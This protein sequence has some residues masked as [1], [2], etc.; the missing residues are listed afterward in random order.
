MKKQLSIILA[1][2]MVLGS[3]SLMSFSVS[4]EEST[5]PKNVADVVP[6]ADANLTLRFYM[7]ADWQ[8]GSVSSPDECAAGIYWWD[9]SY[10]PSE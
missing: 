9:S 2:L 7:P 4:A 6:E 5:A 8:T 10:A 1:V 3:F